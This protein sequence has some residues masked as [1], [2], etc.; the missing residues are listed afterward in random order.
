MF[1]ILILCMPSP[2]FSFQRLSLRVVDIEL[3][4]VCCMTV[5]SVDLMALMVL[6]SVQAAVIKRIL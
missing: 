2:G 1:F 5:D 6:E 3:T 4:V